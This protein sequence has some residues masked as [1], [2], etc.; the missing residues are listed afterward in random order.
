[1]SAA[2]VFCDA[3]GVCKPLKPGICVFGTTLQKNCAALPDAINL[4]MAKRITLF[5]TSN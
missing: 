1:M 4:C 2:D 5:R 3:S